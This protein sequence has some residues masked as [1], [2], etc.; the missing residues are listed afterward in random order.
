MSLNLPERT[1]LPIFAYGIF[2]PGQLGFFQLQKF[3]ANTQKRAY[4]SG[5]LFERDGLP[6]LNKTGMD[7]IKGVLIFFNS[8]HS[9]EAYHRIVKMRP[10]RQYEWGTKQ[11]T[12]GNSPDGHCAN[13]LLGRDLENGSV[14]FDDVE[15]DGREDPLFT[16]A[17]EV[18]QD[19]LEQNRNFTNFKQIFRLQ[20]AYLLLW[21]AIERY[22]TFRYCLDKKKIKKLA[23]EK[24]FYESL[25]EVVSEPRIIH[26]ADKPQERKKLDPSNPTESI[27]Y[28]YTVRSN[29][30]HRGKA[31][32]GDFKI[33]KNS[34]TELLKI[35]KNVLNVAF[36][37]LSNNR[38]F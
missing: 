7:I 4:I 20:M 28:Y 9:S 3:V 10:H 24:A 29:I 37:E 6:L 17:L 13:V 1:D 21:S 38:F 11:V 27:E 23:G 16:S 2:K 25:Q 19:A 12:I 32:E 30:T 22:V 31:A 14:P 15:W 18:V 33:L 26:R 8:E 5:E 36:E 35:F 34:L